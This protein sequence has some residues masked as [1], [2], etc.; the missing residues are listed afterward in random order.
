MNMNIMFSPTLLYDFMH[1]QFVLD[2]YERDLEKR[3]LLN[4]ANKA[5]IVRS[6]NISDVE[7]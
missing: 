6:L 4:I 1:L 3:K 5:K 2:V 7:D